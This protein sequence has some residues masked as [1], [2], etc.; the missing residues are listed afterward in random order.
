MRLRMLA[1]VLLMLVASGLLAQDQ[2]KP[3][4][5]ACR[6]MLN[7]YM[8]MFRTANEDVACASGSPSCPFSGPVRNLDLDQLADLPDK[9][10]AC[11]D[12]D[13]HRRYDYQWALYQTETLIVRRTA[14]YLI[15]KHETDDFAEWDEIQRGVVTPPDPDDPDT[16]AKKN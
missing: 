3:T 8:K 13:R 9:I 10:E 5:A 16:V 15:S 11:L 12:V 4:R 2:P 1:V 14:F 7:Q 6:A